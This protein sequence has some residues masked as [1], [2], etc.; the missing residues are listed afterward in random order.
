M[1]ASASVGSIGRVQETHWGGSM[2]LPPQRLLSKGL[3]P[4]FYTLKCV[5]GRPK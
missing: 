3:P 5:Q 2:E 1:L 4:S